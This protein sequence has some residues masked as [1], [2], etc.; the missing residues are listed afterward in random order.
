MLAEGEE[1]AYLQ[2]CA[3]CYNGSVKSAGVVPA[4]NWY[5]RIP[6]TDRQEVDALVTWLG[7]IP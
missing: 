4:Q 1:I 7:P 5:F 6:E 2:G 3:P